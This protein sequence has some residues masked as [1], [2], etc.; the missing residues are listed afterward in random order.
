MAEQTNKPFPHRRNQDGSFDSICP[1]CFSTVST[2]QNE[3]ELTGD[4]SGHGCFAKRDAVETA[5]QGRSLDHIAECL[6]IFTAVRAMTSDP[7]G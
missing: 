7:E 5:R 6:S 4:E 3:M 2:R 1:Y